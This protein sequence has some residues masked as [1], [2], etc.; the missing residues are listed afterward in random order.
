[1]RV[2]LLQSVGF[3]GFWT[4]GFVGSAGIINAV[5]GVN[6]PLWGGAVLGLFTGLAT[7]IMKSGWNPCMFTRGDEERWN[8]QRRRVALAAVREQIIG[9]AKRKA[10]G[11]A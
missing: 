9:E 8:R 4:G 6:R 7:L 1:M 5:A 2:N 3:L 10:S 11:A